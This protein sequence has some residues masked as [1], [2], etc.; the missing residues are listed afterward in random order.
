MHLNFS[1]FFA[2]NV[3]YYTTGRCLMKILSILKLTYHMFLHTQSV[4]VITFLVRRSSKYR[5]AY[6]IYMERSKWRFRSDCHS[7][8]HLQALRLQGSPSA[9][10]Q[11]CSSE[12]RP[13]TNSV[14][15]S[16]WVKYREYFWPCTLCTTCLYHQCPRQK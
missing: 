15:V 5:I 11:N 2:T 4:Y 16:I 12:N 10:L 1:I 14:R 3:F 9:M 7:Q 8:D 6:S 13:T